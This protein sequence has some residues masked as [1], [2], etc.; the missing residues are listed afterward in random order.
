MVRTGSPRWSFRRQE[1]LKAGMCPA[2]TQDLMCIT[3]SVSPRA[4]RRTNEGDEGYTSHREWATANQDNSYTDERLLNIHLI[5]TVL[6]VRPGGALFAFAKWMVKD[7]TCSL[8]VPREREP[9]DG[10]RTLS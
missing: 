8:H 6:K 4:Q 2:H 3:A 5:K 7:S 9:Q 10:G 1:F